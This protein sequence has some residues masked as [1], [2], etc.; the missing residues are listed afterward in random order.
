MSVRL[1]DDLASSHISLYLS[2]DF[3]I[4]PV[5]TES[6]FNEDIEE[7]N[8]LNLDKD[9]NIINSINMKY[10]D[11]NLIDNKN[12]NG[13]SAQYSYKKQLC[14][15]EP[16]TFIDPI[17]HNTEVHGMH[18]RNLSNNVLPGAGNK[19]FNGNNNLNNSNNNIGYNFSNLTP[20]KGKM[21]FGTY[22]LT[23]RNLNYPTQHNLGIINNNLIFNKNQINSVSH[24]NNFGNM[25][26][27]KA[28]T[29]S[30]VSHQSNISSSNKLRDLGNYEQQE[31]STEVG[32]YSN[33]E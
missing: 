28:N 26:M 9:K 1:S 10:N 4:S 8:E 13:S 15:T 7:F 17:N 12:K 30:F 14:I 29:G 24:P 19:F 6:D 11:I 2:F 21:G 25:M 20:N 33:E 31:E 3:R 22:N 5:I 18:N 16:D 32:D 27:Y 23:P